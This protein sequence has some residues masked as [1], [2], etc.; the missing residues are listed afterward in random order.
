MMLVFVI[1]IVC[2][3]YYVGIGHRPPGGLVANPH[4]STSRGR[5]AHTTPGLV[6]RGISFAAFGLPDENPVIA[7]LPWHLVAS[8]AVSEQWLKRDGLK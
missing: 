2:D 5:D 6:V 3:S 1:R 8:T 7:T 4:R